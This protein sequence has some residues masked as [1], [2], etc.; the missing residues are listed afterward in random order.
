MLLSKGIAQNGLAWK[1]SW[2]ALSAFGVIPPD[3]D[4]PLLSWESRRDVHRLKL[5]ISLQRSPILMPRKHCDLLYPQSSFEHHR[6]DGQAAV[7]RIA[8]FRLG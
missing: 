5:R 6:R 1:P 4:D 7:E 8:L 3:V 2:F